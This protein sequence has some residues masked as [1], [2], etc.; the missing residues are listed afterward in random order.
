MFSLQKKCDQCG[1][2]L[3]EQCHA[4]KSDQF[5]QLHSNEE[6]QILSACSKN[7]SENHPLIGLN[8]SNDNL[9]WIPFQAVM[10]LRL[11]IE[12]SQNSWTWKQFEHLM[13]HE[14]ERKENAE[15]W[16]MFEREVSKFTQFL[17]K[18]EQCFL[19]FGDYNKLDLNFEPYLDL[20]GFY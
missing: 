7:V 3:C 2:P 18:H 9:E 17:L 8:G 5:F 14:M 19:S 13:D 4:E 15:E 10:P 12:A 1:W 6:C 20:I 11:A 16:N